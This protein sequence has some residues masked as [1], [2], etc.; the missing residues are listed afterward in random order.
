MILPEHVH[1]A[2]DAAKES[3]EALFQASDNYEIARF[4]YKAREAIAYV[5]GK[6]EGKNKETRDAYLRVNLNKEMA[7]MVEADR[8]LQKAKLDHDLNTL[9]LSRVRSLVRLV[10]AESRIAN[11]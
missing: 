10:E 2:F 6:V 8:V 1:E 9:E 7:D 4:T 3:R 5:E 11:P